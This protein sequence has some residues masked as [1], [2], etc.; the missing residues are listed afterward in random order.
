MAKPIK[1]RSKKKFE[2]VNRCIMC[3][4][5]IPMSK[6]ICNAC[7]TKRIRALRRLR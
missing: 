4:K 7:N 5:V 2:I 3:G 6:A 1:F